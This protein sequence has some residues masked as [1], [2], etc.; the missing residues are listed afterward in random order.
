VLVADFY[1]QRPGH[2]QLNNVFSNPP[3]CR[4]PDGPPDLPPHPTPHSVANQA[5]HRRAN[6]PAVAGADR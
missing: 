4:V 2:C 3:H 5:T 6:D 1:S